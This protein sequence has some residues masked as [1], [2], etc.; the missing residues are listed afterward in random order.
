VSWTDLRS[1]NMVVCTPNVDSRIMTESSV[2]IYNDLPHNSLWAAS[3]CVSVRVLI[4]KSNML[5]TQK[6]KDV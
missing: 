4:C 1:R 6:C 2:P 3:F 5:A